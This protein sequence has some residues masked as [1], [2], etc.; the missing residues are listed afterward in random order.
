MSH[1]L[2]NTSLF[3]T[4]SYSEDALKI[5]VKNNGFLKS[6]VRNKSKQIVIQTQSVIKK[7]TCMIKYL[8]N[9]WLI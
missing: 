2:K 7:D 1:R 8:L 9:K 4:Q 5:N 6:N 3:C